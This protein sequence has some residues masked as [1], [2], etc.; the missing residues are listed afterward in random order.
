M[1]VRRQTLC[2]NIHWAGCGPLIALSGPDQLFMPGWAK[3]NAVN[4]TTTSQLLR[5]GG[6]RKIGDLTI[7]RQGQRE[8]DETLKSEDLLWRANFRYTLQNNSKNILFSSGRIKEVS[9]STDREK[10]SLSWPQDQIMGLK[11]SY[12]MK[13]QTTNS[14]EYT[15]SFNFIELKHLS[16]HTLGP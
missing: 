2:H 4:V 5:S 12:R 8:T 9:L 14:H 13:S 16:H 11:S 1:A 6:W 10:Q 7:L 3:G 15:D